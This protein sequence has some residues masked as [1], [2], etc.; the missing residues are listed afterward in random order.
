MS[1]H[2]AGEEIIAKGNSAPTGTPSFLSLGLDSTSAITASGDLISFVPRAIG[3]NV[4]GNICLF[5]GTVTL[6]P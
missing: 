1:T 5:L 4:L 6:I 2:S 3:V